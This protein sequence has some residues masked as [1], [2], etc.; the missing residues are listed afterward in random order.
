LIQSQNTGVHKN[1][2]TCINIQTPF[3]NERMPIFIQKS[4]G[5]HPAAEGVLRGAKEN[6]FTGYLSEKRGL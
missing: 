3:V 4:R 2:S 5:S 6:L 1:T